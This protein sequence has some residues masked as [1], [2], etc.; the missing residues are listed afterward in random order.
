MSE[1]NF[2][3]HKIDLA[4]P[5]KENVKQAKDPPK[6]EDKPVRVYGV[7]KPASNIASYNRKTYSYYK[8]L[9]KFNEQKKS[10]FGVIRK[11]PRKDKP[12]GMD[13]EEE[14]KNEMKIDEWDNYREPQDD[15][16]NTTEKKVKESVSESEKTP[17]QVEMD[18]KDK[19]YL[20]QDSAKKMLE[21][22]FAK[23][24]NLTHFEEWRTALTDLVTSEQTM[25]KRQGDYFDE[26][27]FSEWY[28]DA[29][30]LTNRL[31]RYAKAKYSD[32]EETIFPK[33]FEP[34]IQLNQM[35]SD[36]ATLPSDK[37][38]LQR[39]KEEK[40]K[41][42]LV[43][44]RELTTLTS[45]MFS[46]FMSLVKENKELKEQIQFLT[47]IIDDNF[48]ESTR[49]KWK[50]DQR[51]FEVEK[52]VNNW[53]GQEEEML[54]PELKKMERKKKI[55]EKAEKNIE[56]YKKEKVFIEEEEWKKLPKAE[57]VLKRFVFSDVH[58]NVDYWTW[59]EM[60]REQ[61]NKFLTEKTEWRRAREEQIRKEFKDDKAKLDKVMNTFNYFQ[62]R[63]L[64]GMF[65]C[66]LDGYPIRRNFRN[67]AKKPNL[68]K[69]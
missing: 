2:S 31:I 13:L 16:I 20:Q 38:N 46:M 15:E 26:S 68:K 19:F 47:T 17:E 10:P 60:S 59:N 6:E 63:Y 28:A 42:K 23:N 56:K 4:P 7:Y 54:A 39:I 9:K 50:T 66:N 37:N 65:I 18:E 27:K 62:Y 34:E 36:M 35:I 52:V 51:A 43:T 44:Q 45:Y 67:R 64:R 29:P 25:A 8:E 3:R 48:R 33:T 5:K 49:R 57:R 11:E 12:Q 24:P 61:R 40:E 58:Q 41:G 55:K 22:L 14:P 69:D 21:H 1:A 32:P 53:I 30:N